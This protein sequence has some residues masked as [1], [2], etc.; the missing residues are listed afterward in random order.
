MDFRRTVDVNHET[1]V[2]AAL[3]MLSGFVFYVTL[4]ESIVGALLVTGGAW[5]MILPRFIRSGDS[6]TR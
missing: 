6:T 1:E 3:L 5:A 2:G 4:S